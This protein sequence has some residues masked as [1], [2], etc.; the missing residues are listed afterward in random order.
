MPDLSLPA[1]LRFNPNPT[2]QVLTA[3]DG[4]TCVVVDDVLKEPTAARQ[5]ACEQPLMEP[6]GYPYPG[7]VAPIPKAFDRALEEHFN[8]TVRRHLG[9]RRTLDLQSRVSLVTTPVAELRPV[10]WLCHRDRIAANPAEVLFAAS[11][12]YLFDDPSLGGTSL[13]RARRSPLETDRIVADSQSLSA[14][15]FT[16]RYG[17]TPGYMLEDNGWF[18]RTLRV[19]AAFNRAIYYD[20]SVFHSADVADPSRLSTDPERGRLSINGFFT[21]RRNA[22]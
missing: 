16:E 5:W 22:A 20:G 18:E 4:A 13:Y 15:A 9:A 6:T 12:L 19:E 21:C 14:H 8:Q 17:I 11:V 2:I 7:L 1:P 10:Q 3:L